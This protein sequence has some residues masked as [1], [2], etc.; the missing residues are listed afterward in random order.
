VDQVPDHPVLHLPEADQAP[1]GAVDEGV[2]MYFLI[3]SPGFPG[4]F[5]ST[6]VIHPE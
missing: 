4:D 3:A 2:S 5:L 6:R 1:Q